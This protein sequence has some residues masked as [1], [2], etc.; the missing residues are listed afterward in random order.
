MN[1]KTTTMLRLA[2]L[3]TLLAIAAAIVFGYLGWLHPAFDSFSHFRVHLATLLLAATLPL[4]LARLWPEALF[5]VA[6]G[7]TAIVQTIG[8]PSLP[9]FSTVNASTT[10]AGG[11]EALYRLL[12]ANLR[13]DNRRPEETLSLIARVRPDVLTLNE[14]SAP[15]RARLAT[16]EAAYPFQMICERRGHIGGV[17]ILSR[18]PF[19]HGTQ[20]SCGDRGSFAH[21]TIDFGGRVV[22]VV[23]LHLGWPWP[24]EQPW[25]VPRVE[26]L[27]AQ[28]GH[29]AIVAGD[30][31][32]VPWSRTARR[33]EAASGA[34]LL[35]GIGPTW[36]NAR[37]PAW[38]RPAIGLP[39]DNVLVKGAV[40]PL[41]VTTTAEG[42]SDHRP[43]LLEFN[44]LPQEKLRGVLQASLGH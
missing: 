30:L 26:P 1:R 13:F 32:S 7:A 28:L 41:S 39:L 44:V 5:A 9:R 6:L 33:V 35:R 37:L 14:V 4:L 15:W 43:V 19:A 18:R 31:N 29:T 24:F 36:L 12:H 42:A 34:R 2:G 40:M 21:A 38:M 22:E 17:A 16:L 27:L 25:Q 23:A 10:E 8:L 20:P 3:G 11:H